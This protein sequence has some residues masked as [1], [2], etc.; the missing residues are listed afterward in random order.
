MSFS[1]TFKNCFYLLFS[2][3]SIPGR[4]FTSTLELALE[5]TLRNKRMKF[6][7]S[8]SSPLPSQVNQTKTQ[9]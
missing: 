2:Y 9:A 1:K 4:D 8:A 7:N 3:Q 5:K 6:L